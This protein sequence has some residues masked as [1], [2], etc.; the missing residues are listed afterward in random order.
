MTRFLHDMMR[1]NSL[2]VIIEE[3]VVFRLFEQCDRLDLGCGLSPIKQFSQTCGAENAT[4]RL[5]HVRC[6]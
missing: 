4:Q 5:R 1:M 3:V 6:D 2:G